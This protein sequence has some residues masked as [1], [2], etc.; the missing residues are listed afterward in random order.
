MR[1]R[2]EGREC[3]AVLVVNG[4]SAYATDGRPV[5]N[6]CHMTSKRILPSLTLLAGEVENHGGVFAIAAP[7]PSF[8][9]VVGVLEAQD[10][11]MLVAGIG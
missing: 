5:K 10:E 9:D 1:L 8:G 2:K 11:M 6:L 7:S 4:L 3:D